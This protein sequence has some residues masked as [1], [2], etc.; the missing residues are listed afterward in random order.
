MAEQGEPRELGAV[1][2]AHTCTANLSRGSAETLWRSLR[3][4]VTVVR[5]APSGGDGGDAEG[6]RRTVLWHE[7]VGRVERTFDFRDAPAPADRKGGA[8]HRPST[9]IA[10]AANMVDTLTARQTVTRKGFVP[11]AIESYVEVGTLGRIGY[12]IGS[13]LSPVAALPF[14]DDLARLQASVLPDGP[15]ARELQ[16][17]PAT[18]VLEIE[19]TFRTRIVDWS[20]HT[21]NAY[22]F[23]A[24]LATEI[25][26]RTVT[27]ERDG[28]LTPSE[29]LSPTVAELRSPSGYLRGCRLEG[30]P[31]AVA[32][33]AG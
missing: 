22:V 1:R 25:A 6:P 11:H 9:R 13:L 26:I 24:R 7:P 15:T 30:G 20:W 33:A 28:W 27:A 12:Q 16:S 5:L 31:V 19:D 8:R 14:V 21:P 32:E 17:E 29:V 3:E 23:T 10:S 18:V 4:Q 2:I